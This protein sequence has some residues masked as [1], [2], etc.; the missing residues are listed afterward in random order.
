MAQEVIIKR[1]QV[2]ATAQE[3]RGLMSVANARKGQGLDCENIKLDLTEC[4]ARYIKVL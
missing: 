1:N 4:F 3:L 2:Q